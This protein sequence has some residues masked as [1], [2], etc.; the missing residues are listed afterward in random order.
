MCSN[1]IVNPYLWVNTWNIDRI[2]PVSPPQ[3]YS[4]SD[5]FNIMYV[6][7]RSGK[8]LVIQEPLCTIFFQRREITR[9]C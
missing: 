2:F 7:I 5:V 1:K 8:F 9:R 6:L 4:K 3:A